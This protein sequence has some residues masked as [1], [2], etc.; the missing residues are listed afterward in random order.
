VKLALVAAHY[1]PRLGYMEVHLSKA[2]SK[3]GHEVQVFTTDVFPSYLKNQKGNFGDPPRGVQVNRIKPFFTLGQI[4]RVNGLKPRINAYDPDLIIVIGLGKWFPK[5]VY[6]LQTPIYTLLGDNAY[7]Y[8]Q[9]GL[10][11]K[12]LFELFKRSTYKKA[13]KSSEKL[14]TYT[15]ETRDILLSVLGNRYRNQLDKSIEITLG[16]WSSE[17]FFD[18]KIRNEWRA[19]L[20]Y[21]QYDKVIITATR[22]VAEKKLGDQIEYF[23]NA[24]PSV[25]WLILGASDNPYSKELNQ[26]LKSQLGESRYTML[27]Y[28]FRDELNNYYNAADLA[29]FTVPAISIFEAL[30]TGLKLRI[31]EITTLNRISTKTYMSSST[32]QPIIPHNFDYDRASVAMKVRDEF[33]WENVARKILVENPSRS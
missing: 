28:K 23:K 18:Q 24:H 6:D 30:G 26:K 20:G 17:F 9:A 21:A 14:Y 1:I 32:S 11:S 33:E 27:P 15:P 25:K 19:K 10:K 2:F 3:L 16:Y 12:I 8:A 22:V 4:A 7:S 31:P 5:P 13:I 29:L